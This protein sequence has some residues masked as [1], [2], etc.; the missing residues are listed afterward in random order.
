[1]FFTRM[2]YSCLVDADFLDTETFMAGAAAPRGGRDTVETLE[3]RLTGYLQNRFLSGT[4]KTKLNAQRNAILRRCLA[5]GEQ[6]TPG[7][8]SLTVPTGGSKTVSSLAFALCQ[9]KA[10]GL[11]RVVYVLPT[12]RSSNRTPRS[13]G[14][15]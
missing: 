3:K 8:F 12:P 1:M 13:S 6:Q 5:Q 11:R 2:L 7:L 15:S 14:I 10:Y 9:A 4:P